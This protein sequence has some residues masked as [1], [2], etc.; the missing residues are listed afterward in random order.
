[1]SNFQVSKAYLG[2]NILLSPKENSIELAKRIITSDE[3]IVIV[4]VL[5]ENGIPISGIT[6]VKNGDFWEVSKFASCP[7]LPFAKSVAKNAITTRFTKFDLSK[8]IE[9][10]H[11][12]L[13]PTQYQFYKIEYEGQIYYFPKNNYSDIQNTFYTQATF[14]Y[15]IAPKIAKEYYQNLLS[16]KSASPLTNPHKPH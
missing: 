11:F 15:E 4:N 13:L 3:T 7:W 14:A 10:E 6:L 2:K 12:T 1:M 5:D 9:K 16:S 8:V